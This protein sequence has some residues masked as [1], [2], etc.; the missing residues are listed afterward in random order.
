MCRADE[1]VG[2]TIV[3]PQ[4]G[5]LCCRTAGG[6]PCSSKETLR[7]VDPSR[8]ARIHTSRKIGSSAEPL[9]RWGGFGIRWA[10]TMSRAVDPVGRGFG[11]RGPL[12]PTN[13]PFRPRSTPPSA[14]TSLTGGSI[15]NDKKTIFGWVKFPLE[16][17]LPSFGVWPVQR[18]HRVPGRQLRR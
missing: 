11:E 6:L 1:S 15:E 4:G 2:R 17:A 16:P 3:P 14:L 18:R 13:Q 8:Q 7:S 10:W 5:V 12:H 9:S